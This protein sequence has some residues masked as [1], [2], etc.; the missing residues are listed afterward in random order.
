MCVE[1]LTSRYVA[2]RKTEYVA[3]EIKEHI[4][5][6]AFTEYVL[7]CIPEPWK[8]WSKLRKKYKETT[9]VFICRSMVRYFD[10]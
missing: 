1:K 3:L 7:S 4:W 6:Y 10:R 2:R 5:A 9:K 8:A